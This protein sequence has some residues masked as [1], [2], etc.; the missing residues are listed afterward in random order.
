MMLGLASINYF[1]QLDSMTPVGSLQMND[2]VLSLH[3]VFLSCWDFFI[4]V[5]PASGFLFEGELNIQTAPE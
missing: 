3:F 5:F 4:V 2:S 1:L